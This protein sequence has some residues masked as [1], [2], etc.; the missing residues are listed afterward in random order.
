M[1][2]IIIIN[3]IVLSIASAG[4]FDTYILAS[5][6]IIIQIDHHLVYADIGPSPL[7]T[8][9]VSHV[10]ELDDN[11]VEYAQIN[12]GLFKKEV[13]HSESVIKKQP[14]IS[15]AGIAFCDLLS[16]FH[17]PMC[18]VMIMINDACSRFDR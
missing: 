5:N 9:Q 14:P 8:N 2:L 18:N 16:S 4:N 1:L 7:N 15:A 10:L 3:K 12:H 11:R 17:G 13:E 6:I